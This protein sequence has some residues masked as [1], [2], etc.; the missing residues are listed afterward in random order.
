MAPH[1]YV[2]HYWCCGAVYPFT[3]FILFFLDIL[4]FSPFFTLIF[5]NMSQ[6]GFNTI[7][8]VKCNVHSA[9]A[10]AYNIIS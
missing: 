8:L 9:P 10:K 5:R 1:K 6:L 4:S 3:Q 7:N 2:K